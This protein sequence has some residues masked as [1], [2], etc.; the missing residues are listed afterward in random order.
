MKAVT[1]RVSADRLLILGYRSL[2]MWEDVRVNNYPND[3][4]DGDL[5][6]DEMRGN[7]AG[8]S[9]ELLQRF[10]TLTGA[11]MLCMLCWLH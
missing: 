3:G 11:G 6:R 8:L 9:V 4:Q 7:V 5:A 10:V 1:L 2:P